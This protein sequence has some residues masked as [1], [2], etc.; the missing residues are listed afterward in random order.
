M[1]MAAHILPPPPLRDGDRLTSDEFMRRWEAMPD[2]KHAELIDGIVYMPSP[3]SMEH[4]DHHSHLGAW[5][6]NYAAATPGC[7][8]CLEATWLMGD[9]NVPQP[10]IT[11]RI[12]PEFGGRSRLKGKYA[13]GGPE[14]ITEV[15]VSSAGRDLGS[16]LKLYESMGVQEYLVAVTSE[17]RFVWKELASEGYRAVEPDADGLIRSRCF[18]GLWLDVAALW[19]LDLAQM[20]KVLQ[21]GVATAE[22][23]EFAERLARKSASTEI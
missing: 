19:R 3:A 5:L 10:D 14:L 22:H 9:K 15:A 16:K 6:A 18:P 7:R 20:L 12:L 17:T 2:L 23:A 4:G 13:S 21:V 8:S 11:L 1:S